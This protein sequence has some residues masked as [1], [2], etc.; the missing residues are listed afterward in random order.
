MLKAAY[1][2][3]TIDKPTVFEWYKRSKKKDQ[4]FDIS[5]ELPS[6]LDV[7]DSVTVGD[8]TWR[9]KYYPEIKRQSM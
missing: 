2:D 1:G 8:E 3:A 6:C 5:T 9:L 4:N 7:S